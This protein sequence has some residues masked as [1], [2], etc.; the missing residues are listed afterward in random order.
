M[1]NSTTN[2]TKRPCGITL[3][4]AFS[5]LVIMPNSGICYAPLLPDDDIIQSP[6]ISGYMWWHH[7]AGP[8]SV[9]TATIRK[10][11]WRQEGGDYVASGICENY[12]NLNAVDV[13]ALT[14]MNPVGAYT[15]MNYYEDNNAYGCWPLMDDISYTLYGYAWV[16]WYHLVNPV[17]NRLKHTCP[18]GQLILNPS[19]VVTIANNVTGLTRSKKTIKNAPASWTKVDT[20][21]WYRNLDRVDKSKMGWAP[22]SILPD[23]VCYSHLTYKVR[24]KGDPTVVPGAVVVEEEWSV[25][26][27][28]TPVQMGDTSI[29]Q[30]VAQC[31]II[32]V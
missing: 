14:G 1:R 19:P 18:S 30:T 29:P 25:E 26:P 4:I 6:I 10:E 22:A 9:C 11:D 17:A 15:Y 16:G 20:A 8:M 27:M 24:L 32:A 23:L 28:Q 13:V 12:Q 5:V 31:S 3:I 2:K 21:F 7:Q